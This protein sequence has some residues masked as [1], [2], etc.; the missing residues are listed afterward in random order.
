MHYT[1]TL[2]NNAT[3]MLI[4]FFRVMN[5]RERE[6]YIFRYFVNKTFDISPKLISD[7]ILSYA[8]L[9]FYHRD[10]TAYKI[11]YTE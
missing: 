11:T 5:Q 8:H 7:F 10:K 4:M 9:D 2:Y 1:Y 6:K 3:L